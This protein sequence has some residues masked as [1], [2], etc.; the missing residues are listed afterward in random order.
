MLNEAHYGFT[1]E[2]I[3]DPE[4]LKEVMGPVAEATHGTLKPEGIQDLHDTASE[5]SKERIAINPKVV[6]I[7]L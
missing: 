2:V 7:L 5:E 6:L 1:Q 3:G 4:E